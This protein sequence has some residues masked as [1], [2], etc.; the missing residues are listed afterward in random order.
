MFILDMYKLMEG[1][2]LLTSQ[3]G[4]VSKVVRGFTGSDYSHA[5]LY[6][7]HG[8]Y[9]HSDSHGVHSANIQRLIFEDPDNVKVL[10]PNNSILGRKASMYAR[11]QIGK[12]YSVKEAIRTK[13]GAKEKPENRQFCSRLVA[14][15]FQF[16]GQNIVA[17]SAFC[18]P[19]DINKSS[20]FSEVAN[21]VRV[22]STKELEFAN[23]P[24]PIERQAEITNSILSETRRITGCDMQSLEELSMYVI[25]NPSCADDIVAVYKKSGYLTMWMHELSQ[26]PWRYDGEIFMLLPV[27]REEKRRLAEFEAKSAEDQLEL[28]SH[29]YDAFKQY[30]IMRKSSFIEMNMTLYKNLINQMNAR[31]Q[32]ANHVLGHA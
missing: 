6:V 12:E 18:T 14:Q 26:N 3:K 1:D 7:G 31:L 16:A 28:Y 25:E 13:G 11:T 8:S 24:N 22:A 15:S 5:I 32:A 29:N 27:D 17:N 4:L 19:E 2:V 30:S 20:A 10:R 21:V 9:I 23:S